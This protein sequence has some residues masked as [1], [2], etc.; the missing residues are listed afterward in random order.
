MTPEMIYTS[1]VVLAVLAALASNRVP[2][3]VTMMAALVAVLVGD[4]ITPAQ[5]LA[6]FANP[7]LMTVAVLYVVAA[8]LRDT[9][10]IFWVAHKLLGQPKSALGSQ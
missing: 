10:A 2:A 4:V 6:G 8:A 3:E 5:A 7:G 9:G 1:L